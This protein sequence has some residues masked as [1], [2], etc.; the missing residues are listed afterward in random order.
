MGLLHTYPALY[1]GTTQHFHDQQDHD[2]DG[3]GFLT[4]AS[5]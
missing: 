2:R 4:H 1:P 5:L 3:E